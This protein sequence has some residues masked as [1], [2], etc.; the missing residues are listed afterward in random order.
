ML[1][2]L[3]DETGTPILYTAGRHGGRHADGYSKFPGQRWLRFPVRGTIMTAVDQ[4]GNK[5]ARYRLYGGKTTEIIV[6]PDQRLTDE[7][8]LAIA[9]S[10]PWLSSYFRAEGGGG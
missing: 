9:A 2:Q 4:A 8:S 6:H 7:L 10:A 3:L 5:V 1:K